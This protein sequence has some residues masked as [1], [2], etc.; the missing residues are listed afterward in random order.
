[1]KPLSFALGVLVLGLLAAPPAR[2]DYSIIRWSS[3]DCTIW[4][5]V[6]LFATPLGGGWAPIVVEIPTYG[7]ARTVLEGLYRQGMCR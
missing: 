3:G 2:A 1:M 4:D 7:A 6:G 5:N